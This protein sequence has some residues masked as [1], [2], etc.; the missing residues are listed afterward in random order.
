MR[1]SDFIDQ[2]MTEIAEGI[3]K[4]KIS[5]SDIWAISPGSLNGERIFEKSEVEFDVAVTVVDSTEVKSDGK[6][7]VSAK[8]EVMGVSIGANLDGSKNKVSDTAKTVASRISFKVPVYMN[9]H[10]RDDKNMAEEAAY[11]S[12]RANAK[13]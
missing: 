4:A 1:L 2:A 7:G 13:I 5:T 11:F 9:A 3:Q 6:G 8:V 12:S 10:F